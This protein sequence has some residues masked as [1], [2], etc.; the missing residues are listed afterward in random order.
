[1]SRFSNRTTE[2]EL[3]EKCTL[4]MTLL[5][6]LLKPLSPQMTHSEHNTHRLAW[7]FRSVGRTVCRM[8]K[9]VICVL[10]LYTQDSLILKRHWEFWFMVNFRDRQHWSW[11]AALRADIAYPLCIWWFDMNCQMDF[12]NVSISR[13]LFVVPH[14]D[15][16]WWFYYWENRMWT[17]AVMLWDMSN[18]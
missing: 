11:R 18:T 8:M 6:I 14:L 2:F 1:M 15:C 9:S 12:K 5:Q 10:S 17:E 13:L 3:W 7:S 16:C 4:M